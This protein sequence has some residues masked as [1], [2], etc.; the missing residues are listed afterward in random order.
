[1]KLKRENK[2]NFREYISPFTQ[3]QLKENY[4]LFKKQTGC[5]ITFDEYVLLIYT[6][7]LF[8][9]IGYLI[10]SPGEIQIGLNWIQERKKEYAEFREKY[11]DISQATYL[12]IE[13]F[14]MLLNHISGKIERVDNKKNSTIKFGQ[15]KILKYA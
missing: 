12:A 13:N 15:E 14:T 4:S 5:D 11:L 3:E 6:N 7:N 2:I 9:E 8:T 1:M 10:D